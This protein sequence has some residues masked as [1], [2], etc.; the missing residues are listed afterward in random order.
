MNRQEFLVKILQKKKIDKEIYSLSRKIEGFEIA[1]QILTKIDGSV[2]LDAFLNSTNQETAIIEKGE[3]Y[4]KNIA[5]LRDSLL[6]GES[7]KFL[8]E[9]LDL[10]ILSFNRDNNQKSKSQNKTKKENLSKF[11]DNTKIN[12]KKSKQKEKKETFL[13][14]HKRKP[15]AIC[16]SLHN[17]YSDFIELIS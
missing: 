16:N 4:R 15:F 17:Y 8:Q 11:K 12:N 14:S 9:L 3:L 7:Q 13:Q 5:L 10:K 6:K 1:R 2:H